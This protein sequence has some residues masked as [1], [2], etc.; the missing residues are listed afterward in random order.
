MTKLHYDMLQ[1][2]IGQIHL[3]VDVKCYQ[4]SHQSNSLKITN[5]EEDFQKEDTQEVEV[6]QEVEEDSQVE[7]GT[8]EEEVLLGLD[9]QKAVG[10]PHLYKYHKQTTENW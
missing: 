4:N 9:H 10:D 7:E 6:F 1:A 8:P 3:V 5:L 2:L